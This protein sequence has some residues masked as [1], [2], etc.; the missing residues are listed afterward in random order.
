MKVCRSAA[1]ITSRTHTQSHTHAHQYKGACW[2][3]SP[4][5]R[6]IAKSTRPAAVKTLPVM[7]LAKM[8]L[9]KTP[10]RCGERM[11]LVLQTHCLRG[12]YTSTVGL[13]LVAMLGPTRGTS[14]IGSPATEPAPKLTASGTGS[15]SAS[16]THRQ[17]HSGQSLAAAMEEAMDSRLSGWDM[18]TMVN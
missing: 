13:M 16:G 6:S 14:V 3:T 8:G 9:V 1:Y 15:L 10:S 18:G 7:A 17:W 5:V 4:L 2:A 12:F 11:R